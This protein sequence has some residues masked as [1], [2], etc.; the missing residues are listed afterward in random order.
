MKAT[1]GDGKPTRGDGK[2]THE[3]GPDDEDGDTGGTRQP[4]TPRR[5]GKS[6]LIAGRRVQRGDIAQI[7]LKVSETVTHQPARVPVTV[8]RGHKDGPTLFLT[9][10]V[11]GDEI[12]GIAVVREV[13]D[14]LQVDAL[15]GTLVGIPVVNRFGF[16]TGE[17]YLPDRRDLNRF[18][19]GDAQGP[20][21]GRIADTLFRKVLVKCD[22]GIDIHTATLGRANLCHVR[23]RADVPAVRDLMRAFGTPVMMDGEG[24][25]GSLRRAT[26]D[27]GVPAINF[28][29]GEPNRFQPHVVEIGTQGVFR[30][31]RHLGMW[32][33]PGRARPA[34]QVLV[35]RSDWLRSDHGGVLDLQV[36]PGD[37]VRQGQ[38][39]AV[40]HDPFGR[41]VD[42]IIADRSGV[43]LGVSTVPLTTPGQAIVHIGHLD[44]TFQA[45]QRY[46]RKGGDLGHVNWPGMRAQKAPKKPGKRAKPM[47]GAAKSAGKAGGAMSVKKVKNASKVRQAHKV[48]VARKERKVNAARDANEV[49]AAS[50]ANKPTQAARTRAAQGT[51]AT[52]RVPTA[53]FTKTAQ[54]TD[55]NGAAGRAAD[56]AQ[57]TRGRDSTRA[58]RDVDAR[59]LGARD[60]RDQHGA[61]SRGEA[62]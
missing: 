26:T 33:R 11:H 58:A 1:R 32:H 47:K 44:K 52:A 18:F 62:S 9:A 37:L 15:S 43:V 16:A 57:K 51:A 5:R 13:L 28:E 60:E 36:E 39:I 27:A 54:P 30:V 59:A 22:A 45:A 50:R 46:C 3:T 35:R 21:P 10:A 17:R 12:N 41:H 55:G 38:R 61:A 23:G 24:P 56:A 42:E 49:N 40:I 8:A 7:N 29:A 20:M 2:R 25:R 6:P 14:R 34:F 19:P 48:N 4:P 53:K 31:M